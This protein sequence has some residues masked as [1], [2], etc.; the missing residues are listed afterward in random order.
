M[1]RVDEEYIIKEGSTIR[2]LACPHLP[3]SADLV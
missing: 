3:L 1:K 2:N